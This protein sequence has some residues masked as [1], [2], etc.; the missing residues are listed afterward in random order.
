MKRFPVEMTARFH[1][2]M[3]TGPFE[4]DTYLLKIVAV[5]ERLSSGKGD[6]AA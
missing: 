4:R 6:S 2:D 5:H 1:R 3:N